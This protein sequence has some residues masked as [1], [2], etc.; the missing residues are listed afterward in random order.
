MTVGTGIFL[1]V[2]GAIIRWGINVSIAGIEEDTIGLILIIA[3][4]VVAVLG[5]FFWI[6]ARGGGGYPPDDRGRYRE[7]PRREPPAY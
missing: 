6:N 7:D 4:V 2:V 5:L 3:G 1:I